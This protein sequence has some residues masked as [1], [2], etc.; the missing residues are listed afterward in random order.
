MGASEIN[1][2]FLQI[3][4]LEGDDKTSKEKHKC[5]TV[6]K[7]LSFFLSEEILLF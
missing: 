4:W 3:L 5:N 2:V 6:V 7:N 1:V